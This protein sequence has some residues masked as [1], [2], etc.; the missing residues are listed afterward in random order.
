MYFWVRRGRGVPVKQHGATSHLLQAENLT[1]F[2]KA[3]LPGDW[4]HDCSD[5]LVSAIV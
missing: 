4:V 1:K 2:H 5:S 3:R